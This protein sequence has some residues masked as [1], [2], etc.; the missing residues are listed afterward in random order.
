M[1]R[2]A[3]LLQLSCPIFPACLPRHGSPM[4]FLL[5]LM[6]PYPPQTQ[7]KAH[8]NKKKKIRAVCLGILSSLSASAQALMTPSPSS[9]FHS[10]VWDPTQPPFPSRLLP[11][12]S[13]GGAL[14]ASWRSFLA[15]DGLGQTQ[16]DPVENLLLGRGCECPGATGCSAQVPLLGPNPCGGGLTSAGLRA[17]LDSTRA[18]TPRVGVSSSP[19]TPPAAAEAP[20]GSHGGRVEVLGVR[21]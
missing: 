13:F 20:G 11:S 8:F 21:F 5:L 19:C 7:P 3:D 15:R 18:V 6:F 14:R 17:D 12:K 2:C 4:G 9:R 1:V 16:Q 10:G